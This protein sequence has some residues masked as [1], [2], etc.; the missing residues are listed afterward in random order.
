M[1]TIVDELEH[2]ILAHHQGHGPLRG[3]CGPVIGEGY[4][5][6]ATCFGCG[7]S[8]LRW[9]TGATV[10]AKARRFTGNDL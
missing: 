1:T 4:T 7:T 5:V 3:D 8:W 2:F 6:W 10:E 9:V